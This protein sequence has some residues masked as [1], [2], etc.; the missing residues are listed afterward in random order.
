MLD[1]G[2]NMCPQTG[3]MSFRM[4]KTTLTAPNQDDVTTA[5]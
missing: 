2:W 4:P 1:L 3:K 5:K